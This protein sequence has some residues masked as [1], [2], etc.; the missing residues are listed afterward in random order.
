MQLE[1]LIIDPQNDFSDVP[2]AALPVPGASADAER[3]AGLLDRLGDRIAAIHVTLDTHQLVDIAHPV[4]WLD[5]NGQ[6]PAPFTQITAQT[7]I[8]EPLPPR[9]TPIARCPLLILVGVTGVGKSTTLAALR[10]AGLDAGGGDG[11]R[12][13]RGD[14]AGLSGL[15]WLHPDADR[16]RAVHF[17]SRA[18]GHDGADRR[19]VVAAVRGSGRAGGAELRHGRERGFG[20]AVAAEQRAVDGDVFAVVAATVKAGR[21]D[22]I[23]R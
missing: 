1:F 15:A 20:R 7:A 17:R 8:G 12:D 22:G 2:G 19:S 16:E 13:A 5:R 18:A 23:E 21:D 14:A 6:Q 3:L 10:A 4:F 11:G 9:W